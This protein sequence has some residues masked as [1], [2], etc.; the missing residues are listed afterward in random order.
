MNAEPL[1]IKIAAALRKVKLEAVMIGSA[2]AALRGAPVTTLDFDFMYRDTRLNRSKIDL[3]G[4]E[5]GMEIS[6][7][8]LPVSQF[9]RLL[10]KKTG[11]QLDFLSDV[12]AVSSFAGLRAR[13]DAV[14][15]G[16]APL[17]VASL[18]DIL[19]SK[20]AAGRPKDIAVLHELENTL[21]ETKKKN[22]TA[23]ADHR[24]GDGPNA[25]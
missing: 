6:Q 18:E 8:A 12:I 24:G 13:S 10:D 19:K 4:G 2:A 21:L 23:R 22:Q 3:L 17:L 25:V 11:I 20:R 7:P 15:F 5:L 1:L 14:D 16:G 9:F